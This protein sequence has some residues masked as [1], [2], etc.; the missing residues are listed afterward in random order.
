[1]GPQQFYM[2]LIWFYHTNSRSLGA[3]IRSRG[4]EGRGRGLS[5]E[6]GSNRKIRLRL[7]ANGVR[8]DT[9]GEFDELHAVEVFLL[10]GKYPEIGDYHVDNAGPRQR[11]S[12]FVQELGLVLGRMLHD[13][14]HLL[15]A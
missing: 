10:D 9:R 2:V 6:I 12:A 11:Q 4:E 7:G 8:G 14:H 13:D 3:L 1:M 15:D 5:A